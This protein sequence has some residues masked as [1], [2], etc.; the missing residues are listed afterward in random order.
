MKLIQNSGIRVIKSG[1]LQKSSTVDILPSIHSLGPPKRISSNIGPSFQRCEKVEKLGTIFDM[2]LIQNNEIRVFK[3]GILQKSSTV[4]ILLSIH[5]LGPPKRISSNIGASFQRCE[6]VEKLGTI[7]DM[8]LIQNNE[9]RVFKSGILQKSSTVD[10]LSSMHSLGQSKR[11]SSNIGPSFQRYKKIETLGTNFDMKLI[12]NS[13]IRVFKS[14]IPQKSHIVDFMHWI[15]FLG[16]PKRISSSIGPSFQ[17][18]EKLETLGT[19][20]DMKLIQNS[21]IRVFKYGIPQKS[22]IVDFMHWI[23]FLGPPKRISSSIGP[24]LQ[25][26]KKLE[27]LGTKFDMKLI[28]NSKIRVFKSGIPQKSHIVDFMHWIHFLGPPKRI[29][30][31]IGPM[32]HRCRDFEKLGTLFCLKLFQNN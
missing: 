13:E 4:D 31:N 15:H 3:S 7:F 12:Q 22:H 25:R 6:K 1:I 11:I 27:T 9:I 18:C 30:S 23:H 21:E 10:L 14:G 20:F 5:S 8:K 17:R 32:L 28:Q 29:S 16:P 19:N 26:C 24:S 2:K